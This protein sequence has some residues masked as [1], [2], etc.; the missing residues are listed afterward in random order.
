MKR[1]LPSSIIIMVM[2]GIHGGVEDLGI[3]IL[4]IIGPRMLLL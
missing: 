2:G 4:P 1:E 3:T